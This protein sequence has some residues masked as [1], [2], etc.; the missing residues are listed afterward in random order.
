[1]S[2][3]AS[4]N[5]CTDL[6]I[7][8]NFQSFSTETGIFFN[9]PA[10]DLL[11]SLPDKSVDFVFTDPPYGLGYGEYDR[12]EAFYEVLGELRRVCRGYMAVWWAVKKLPDLFYAVR[13]SGWEYRW[14][15]VVSFR[16][17]KG[18]GMVGDRGYVPVVVFGDGRVKR[19]SS[20]VVIGDYEIDE[21]VEKP[22]SPLY[23]PTMAVSVI[24]SYFTGKGDL[25]VDPFAGLGSI[26]FVCHW[27]GRRWFASEINGVVFSGAMEYFRN[28]GVRI[29][30]GMG[31]R[32]VLKIKKGD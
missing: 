25:V 13:G 17:G 20:D 32:S 12:E 11:K 10:K 2:F 21:V 1:M 26:P 30:N 3:S 19:R 29:S 22:K 8:T 5:A 24:L 23:K 7:L 14:M 16:G 31:G 15:I 6:K 18:K 4:A 27:R 9:C 28:N